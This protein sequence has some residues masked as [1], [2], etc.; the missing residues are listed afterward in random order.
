MA[1]QARPFDEPVAEELALLG[2]DIRSAISD[3]LAGLT[4]IDDAGLAPADKQQLARARAT[5][6]SLRNYLRD[7]LATLLTQAPIVLET[8]P[9]DLD[10][11]LEDLA[12]RWAYSVDCNR[13]SLRITKSDLPHSIHCNRTAVDRV[14]SNLLSNAIRHSQGKP[15]TLNVSHPSPDRLCFAVI[16]QGPGFPNMAPQD[17]AS[18]AVRPSALPAWENHEGHGLGLNIALNLAKRMAAKLTFENRAGGGGV[19]RFDLPVTVAAPT[20]PPRPEDENSLRGKTILIA[21]DSAPQ[22]LLLVRLLSDCGAEC[23]VVREGHA[24]EAA[25]LA[26]SYDLALIDLEMPGRTGLE[27]CRAYCAHPLA[28]TSATRIVILTAHHLDT[29]HQSAISAG[30]DQVLVK[31]IT[32]AS[33]LV[34][35]LAGAPTPAPALAANAAQEPN[36]QDLPAGFARLLEIAGPDM[37]SELLS[38]YEED[39]AAVQ[40]KLVS[41]LPAQDWQ[42]LRAA[43][44]VLIALSGTAGMERLEQSARSFNLA[45]NDNDSVNLSQ[46]STTVLDGL[47]DLLVFVRRAAQERQGSR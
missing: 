43:S 36:P 26:G 21:D 23:S 9:T 31:P 33:G 6:E 39:L 40:T 3:I 10:R 15:V 27:I 20:A 45:A 4:S 34:S 1:E 18:Q 42:V 44:H 8:A 22:V 11:L 32:S 19:A 24:A 5:G 30:A 17:G 46:H 35:A 16:D 38:R 12:H 37:A 2:H 41:A 7:G 13:S 47:A 25:L 29:I 28:R 14:L